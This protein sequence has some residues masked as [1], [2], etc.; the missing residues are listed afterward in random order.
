[1]TGRAE[2]KPRTS[3]SRNMNRGAHSRGLRSA[4]SIRKVAVESAVVT[5]IPVIPSGMSASG[6]RQ[7]EKVH[8]PVY[9]V[10]Y[11]DGVLVPAAEKGKTIPRPPSIP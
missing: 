10:A 9:S 11:P 2:P 7:R 1:M 3:T 4:V 8:S 6:F 5:L